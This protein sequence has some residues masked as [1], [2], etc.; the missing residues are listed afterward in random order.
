MRMFIVS[1]LVLGALGFSLYR[2]KPVRT[3]VRNVL[4][5][6][7]EQAEDPVAAAVEAAKAA[8]AADEDQSETEDAEAAVAD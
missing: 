7:P 1:V 8:K 5:G 3:H 4:V 6:P 2:W